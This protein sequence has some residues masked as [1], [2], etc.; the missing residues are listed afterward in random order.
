MVEPSGS[1][2]LCLGNMGKG[3]LRRFVIR[4]PSFRIPRRSSGDRQWLR[5][6]DQRAESVANDSDGVGVGQLYETSQV[7]DFSPSK[8]VRSNRRRLDPASFLNDYFPLKVGR[9]GGD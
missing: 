5:N 8:T 9:S 1:V 2:G 6:E 4:K 7:V 3:S